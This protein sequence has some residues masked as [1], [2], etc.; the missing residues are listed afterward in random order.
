M[1]RLLAFA[2]FADE[3]LEFGRGLSTDD[4]PALWIRDYTGEV[5]LWID[6]GLPDARLVRKASSRADEV[7]IL[8]YGGQEVDVWW[9][10]SRSALARLNNLRVLALDSDEMDALSSLAER[11]MKLQCTMQDGDI[12]LTNDAIA[13]PVA[14][15]P[16]KLLG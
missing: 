8:A 15:V 13:S 4:E 10:K 14:I 2:L 7:V 12:W 1:V 3:S 11:S 9:N 6:V 5:R 16:R